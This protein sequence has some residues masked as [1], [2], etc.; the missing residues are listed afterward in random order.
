MGRVAA[1]ILCPF[2]ALNLNFILFLLWNFGMFYM[3]MFRSPSLGRRGHIPSLDRW[4]C[5]G[6][7]LSGPDALPRVPSGYLDHCFTVF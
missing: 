5:W 3:W 2:S 7:P 4:A 1:L 6:C